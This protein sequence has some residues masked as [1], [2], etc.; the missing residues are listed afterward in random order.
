MHDPVFLDDEAEIKVFR[1]AFDGKAETRY[2]IVTKAG[3]VLLTKKQ[4]NAVTF[5]VNKDR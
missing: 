5:A 2:E 1:I 3:M 4:L